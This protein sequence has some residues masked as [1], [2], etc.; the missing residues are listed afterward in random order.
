[1]TLVALILKVVP[2]IQVAIDL[3]NRFLAWFTPR[4]ASFV[5]LL[6]T[7]TAWQTGQITGPQALATAISTLAVIFGFLQPTPAAK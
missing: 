2:A 4:K 7:L 1:M 3:F 6:S 5:A